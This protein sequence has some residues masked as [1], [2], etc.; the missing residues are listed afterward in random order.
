MKYSQI[1]TGSCLM[2]G[3]MSGPATAGTGV[4]KIVT[5]FPTEASIVRA[6]G[7]QH[8]TVTSL[9]KATKDPHVVTPRPNM[10]VPINRADL[11]ITNGQEGDLIWL[12]TVLSMARNPNLL[13]GEEGNFDPSEGTNLIPYASEELRETPFFGQN[14]VAGASK[15]GGGQVAVRHG[16]HHYLLDPANG[17]VVAHNIA[18]KLAE[19]DPSDAAD[20]QANAKAFEATLKP[21]MAA[22]DKAMEPFKGTPVVCDHRDWTYLVER[23]GLRIEGYIEP[24]ETFRPNA[25]DKA[26]LEAHMRE[27]KVHVLLNSNWQEQDIAAEIAKAT[28]AQVVVLPAAVGTEIGIA[29]YVGLFEAVYAKLIP[30]LAAAR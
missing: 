22:W 16:N 26:K 23:H 4:L 20:F 25:E 8:V 10:A 17:I 27:T 18:D 14:L 7:G 5:S 9:T 1:L 24:K 11:L 29:D 12:P 2:L 6:V 13:E 15:A 28:D 30:A 21:K 3:L 19:M